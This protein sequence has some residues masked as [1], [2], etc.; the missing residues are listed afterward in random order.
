MLWLLLSLGHAEPPA[1]VRYSVVVDGLAA[2]PDHV[3]VV[4]PWSNSNTESLDELV[5][6]MDGQPL[7]FGR[8]TKG[9]PAF[10]ALK[11]SV[12]QAWAE[13]PPRDVQALLASG[14]RCSG[15]ISPRF[16]ATSEPPSD[17]VDVFTL[18]SI[19]EQGCEIVGVADS[20]GST[21]CQT[22]PGGL[23]S[24]LLLLLGLSSRRR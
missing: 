19:D 11:R 5:Q 20:S 15:A 18:V 24:M 2:F 14:Q 22:A 10:Y 16:A 17:I 3:V 9:A 8:G 6:L 1:L 13:T 12:L 23:W 4:Y 21:G 7:S